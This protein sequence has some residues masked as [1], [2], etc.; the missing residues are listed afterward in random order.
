MMMVGYVTT[1]L[2]GVFVVLQMSA[3]IMAGHQMSMQR[4]FSLSQNGDGS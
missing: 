1:A 3:A 4:R 2:H